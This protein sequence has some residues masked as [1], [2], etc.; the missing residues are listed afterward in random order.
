M[1]IS[2]DV[3]SFVT[4]AIF[5]ALFFGLY[6]FWRGRVAIRESGEL[7][8]HR[9]RQQRLL[10][11]WQVVFWAL[12]LLAV[13]GWLNLYGEATVYAVFPVTA[14]PSPPVTPSLTPSPS[15]SPTTTL[16]PS[17]TPTLEFTYTPS[18]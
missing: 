8:Y 6:A 16:T 15:L 9:L 13:A 18:P 2:L 11:G 10:H 1:T 7:P 14:T 3:A 12:V 5:V 17:L 4:T